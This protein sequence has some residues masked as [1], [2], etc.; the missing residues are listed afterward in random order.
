VVKTAIKSSDIIVK[1]VKDI[2]VL[3]VQLIVPE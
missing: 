3:V 1:P 2:F